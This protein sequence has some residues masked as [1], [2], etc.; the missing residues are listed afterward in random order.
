ML[1]FS[2][3]DET[4]SKNIKGETSSVRVRT[5]N[6]VDL[7]RILELRTTVQWSAD[8]GAF[9][10]LRGFK[11][12]RWAVAEARDGSLVGM[13]GAVP[14]GDIGMVC[15]LA[16]HQGY[17]RQGL[18]RKLTS[19]AVF[20]L[21]SQGSKVIRLESTS[22]AEDLYRALGF[23]D[24]SRRTLY[25]LEQPLAT[26]RTVSGEYEIAPLTI[27]D[28][29]ELYGVDRWSF[30]ADRSMLLLTVLRIRWGWGFVA[31][32][33]G[34]RMVGYLVRNTTRIGPWMAAEP[35]VAEDLLA[36]ALAVRQTDGPVQVMVPGDSPA[37]EVLK[38]YGFTGRLD[39]LRMELGEAPAVDGLKTYGMTPYLAT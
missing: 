5:M 39:R 24:I 15:H 14:F 9:E 17:R 11:D 23:E 7:E 31:R 38:G 13:V 4:E 30:G 34:G 27:G 2:V 18:G 6:D 19:W 21:R 36:H 28:L 26:L 12:A 16:V 32:D 20:Y 22:D 35:H 8:P 33:R 29:P 37:H 25:T 1:A 3:K 10:L